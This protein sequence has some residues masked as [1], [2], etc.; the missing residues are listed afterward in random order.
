MSQLVIIGKQ[1]HVRNH[2][3]SERRQ[4]K[5]ELSRSQPRALQDLSPWMRASGNETAKSELMTACLPAR[6][7]LQMDFKIFPTTVT[8]QAAYPCHLHTEGHFRGKQ[9]A[10]FL[11]VPLS[12][13]RYPQ[14]PWLGLWYLLCMFLCQALLFQVQQII[15]GIMKLPFPSDVNAVPALVWC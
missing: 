2:L 14:A 15:L 10:F 7:D 8:I 6:C 11:A 4:P 1:P 13:Y 3:P 12:R 5:I 9:V